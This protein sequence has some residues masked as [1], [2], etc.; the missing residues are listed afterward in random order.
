M[1]TMTESAGEHLVSM[2]DG[3]KAPDEAAVRLVMAEG[4]LGMRADKAKDDDVTFEHD[5]RT[6][7]VVAPDVAAAL[8]DRTLDAV[9]TEKGKGLTLS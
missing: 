5:G 9:D 2:L 6:V 7:L 3:A 4:G 1:L 8:E